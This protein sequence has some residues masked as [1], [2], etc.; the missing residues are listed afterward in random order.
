MK[1]PEQEALEARHRWFD[2]DAKPAR[3]LPHLRSAVQHQRWTDLALRPA[4]RRPQPSA[5]A[6]LPQRQLQQGEPLLLLQQR[7]LLPLP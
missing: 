1:P 3:E 4:L 6:P 2:L 5:S 7:F